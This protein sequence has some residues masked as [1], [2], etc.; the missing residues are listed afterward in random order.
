MPSRRVGLGC[1]AAWL[2]CALAVRAEEPATKERPIVAVFQLQDKGKKLDAPTLD[3]LTELLATALA[4]GGV[5]RIVPPGDVRR[6][7]V[8]K[9]KESYKECYDQACQIELGRELAAGKS[10]SGSILRLEQSCTVTL[11]LYDLQSQTTDATA[12]ET[13]TGCKVSELQA[14]LEEAVAALRAFQQGGPAA[15]APAAKPAEPAPAPLPALP[16]APT[17]GAAAPRPA[18]EYLAF[19]QEVG[20][21]RKESL[22]ALRR[23]VEEHPEGPRALD[24]RLAYAQALL[25]GGWAAQALETLRSVRTAQGF[26]GWG[27][28]ALARYLMAVC[29]AELGDTGMA[30]VE[31]MT[32]DQLLRGGKVDKKHREG[33]RRASS[34]L[35]KK[36][37]A[38]KRR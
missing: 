25:V 32:V 36:L 14:A 19:A 38:D 22:E 3:Q 30:R 33:L 7:L 21:K 15:G 18:G 35:L 27:G 13:A 24:A 16:A 34:R 12:K 8:E 20:G 28:A 17:E 1:V 4:E 11:A 37:R 6:A 29:L 26:D 2:V 10:L 9:S 5:F 23:L 31:L